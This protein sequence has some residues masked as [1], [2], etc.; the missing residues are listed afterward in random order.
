MHVTRK[1]WAGLGAGALSL[2]LAAAGAVAV[3]PHV[4]DLPLLPLAAA[5]AVPDEFD[6]FLVRVAATAPLVPVALGLAPV[7]SAVPNLDLDKMSR[8]PRKVSM[9]QRSGDRVVAVL[10]DGSVVDVTSGVTESPAEEPVGADVVHVPAPLRDLATDPGVTEISQVDRTTWRVVGDVTQNRVRESTGLDA[11][12]DAILHVTSNDTYDSLLWALDNKGG[13]VG[14]FPAV[15]DADVDGVESRR[16]ADGAGVVVAIVDTGMQLDHPDLPPVWTNPGET[17]GNGVDDDHNGYVDDCTGWDFAHDDNTIFDAADSNDHATHIAGTIAAIPDNGRGIAGLAPGATIMPLKVSTNGSMLTSD[18]AEAIRYAADN[19]AKVIN[20]S[21]G[22]SPGS[23]PRSAVRVMEDAIAYAGSKGVLVAAAAGNDGANTDQA[24][25]WPADLPLDNIIS[26]GASTA[27][28]E[29]ASFSNYGASTVDIFAPGHYIASTV[30]GSRYAAMQGTS[31]ATPHVAAA[32]AAVLSADPSLTPAQL[33]QRLMDTADPVAAYQNISVT[34]GRLNAEQAIGSD[35]T[36]RGDGFHQFQPDTEHTGVLN[37]SA[38]SGLVPAGATVALRATLATA[39]DG[40]T[41]GVINH[42]VTV[43]G[44]AADTDESAQ[45]TLADGLTGADLAGGGLDVRL[46]TSLPTGEYA[47]VLDVVAADDPRFAYG[48][49]TALFFAVGDPD[50]ATTPD[51][52]TA[53]DGST[54]GSGTSPGDTTPGDGTTPGSGGT[55]G[56]GDTPGSTPGGS[57]PGDTTP[58]GT[59]PGGTTPGGTTPGGTT[60]GETVPGGTTPGSGTSPGDTTPGGGTAPGSGGTPGS[61]DTP[62]STPGG[63]TPGDTSPGSGGTPDSGTAPGSP[64]SPSGPGTPADGGTPVTPPAPVSEDGIRITSLTP[65]HGPASGGT[66][67]IISGSGFPEYPVVTI[68]GHPVA[69][70]GQ[71]LNSLTVVTPGGTAGSRVDV[72]V[73][74]HGDRSVTMPGGFAY[75]G[76]PSSG[77]G[78]PTAPDTGTSPGGSTP[79]DTTPGGTT[80]GGSTPGDTTPGGSTPGD[81]TPGDTTP[82]DTAPGDVTPTGPAGSAYRPGPT[83]GDSVSR[84]GLTLAPFAAN[85][86]LAAMPPSRWPSHRCGTAGCT[87]VPV[88]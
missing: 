22:G 43:D 63:S 74:D 59:T 25:V 60:P 7:T 64:G 14:G 8:L 31:M 72:T 35:P 67:V 16:K 4:K 3:A 5:G 34:G 77:G 24:A 66:V 50:T 68:G 18:I 17:C 45:V 82:G 30:P 20:A 47:L 83:V 85:N 44:S 81:T 71:T 37:V 78:S 52:G 13:S 55:P 19:G 6:H 15:A 73:A 80:P 58:G 23:A 12:E 21:F 9:L 29:R 88:R 61:G 41:Y 33:R 42:P 27:A 2:T 32:A 69:V 38:S 79:G 53:P 1:V 28:E 49:S 75:D 39:V 54:P 62:G 76:D 36:V 87:A 51:A 57:T 26:V 11:T 46:G 65:Y 40:A 70:L 86:P 84:N 10:E 56:S 48:R